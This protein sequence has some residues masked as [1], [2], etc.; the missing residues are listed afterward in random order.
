MNGIPLTLAL[1][2]GIAILATIAGEGARAAD[3]RPA[4]RTIWKI[5]DTRRRKRF[6]TPFVPPD[7]H[8]LSIAESA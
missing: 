3:D 8:R 2:I 5:I 6:V 7:L 4:Y 1:L